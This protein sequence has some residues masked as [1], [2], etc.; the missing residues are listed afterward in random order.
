MVGYLVH[1]QGK[2]IRPTLT[3]LCA[4]L[5]SG[6]L[7][8]SALRAA[9]IVE[10]LHEATLVHD[11][12]VDEAPLRRGFPSL[13]ARFKNKVAVLFGDYMLANVLAE[14]LSSRDLRWLDILSVTARRMARGELLQA[15]RS[16]RLDMTE[17]DYLTMVS[18]KTAALFNA[19]C[20]L[21]AL[22]GGLADPQIETLG[23]YGESLGVI[24]QIRDDLLDLFGDGAG[25]GKSPGGDLR[26]R[27]LTL[28]VI[29][30]LS[31]ASVRESRR[32]RARIRRG[33]KRG[34]IAMVAEFVRRNGG[35]EYARRTMDDCARRA[36]GALELV[37]E[38]PVRAILKELLD[39]N[40]NRGR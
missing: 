4:R 31:R 6:E 16:R 19:C 10:L 34:E 20:R 23:V 1:T 2:G 11:D 13:P 15:A 14:T 21:G 26:E 25:L 30:A 27:K 36:A 18:D 35:E 5:G 28:P 9:V 37:P 40:L 33:I 8:E 29:A 3:L 39:Y 17:A 7:N 38:S 32:H 12:V 22:T 24:F